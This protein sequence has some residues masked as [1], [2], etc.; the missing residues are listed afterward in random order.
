MSRLTDSPFVPYRIAAVLVL[1]AFYVAR[2]LGGSGS[3]I[4]VAAV[5]VPLIFIFGNY[6]NPNRES[7]S[8]VFGG[9]ALI[10]LLGALL[11]GG[12]TALDRYLDDWAFAGAALAWGALLL[13]AFLYTL[14]RLEGSRGE[15]A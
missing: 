8:R 1:V 15:S 7:W 4:A 9:I 6:R 13:G 5:G 3:A 12:M 11:V 14:W 2:S 10:F